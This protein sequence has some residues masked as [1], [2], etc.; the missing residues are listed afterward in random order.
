MRRRRPGTA[1][2]RIAQENPLRCTVVAFHYTP[3]VLEELGRHGV[4]PH[5]GTD[6]QLVRDWL[7]AVYKVEIRAL[8]RRL[9]RREFPQSEYAGRVRALRRNY[10]L[11]SIP[12]EIWTRRE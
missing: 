6:P 11:L 7:S 10:V 8:K 12:L 1:G 5:E 3:E 9:L 4:A 2:A